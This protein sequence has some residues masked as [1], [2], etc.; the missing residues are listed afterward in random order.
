[1]VDDGRVELRLSALLL[2]PLE[3]TLTCV[4]RAHAQARSSSH[5]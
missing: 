3:E 1:M 4:E 5:A 2:Y